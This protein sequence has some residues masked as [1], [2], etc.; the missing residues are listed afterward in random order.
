MADTHYPADYIPWLLAWDYNFLP[1]FDAKH[2][3]MAAADDNIFVILGS[4]TIDT[5]CL[6]VYDPDT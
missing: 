6:F 1:C 2:E 4:N 5:R 3:V